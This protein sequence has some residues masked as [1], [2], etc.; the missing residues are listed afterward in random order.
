MSSERLISMFLPDGNLEGIRVIE[1][2]DSA[3][4]GF[5]VP[6]LKLNDT[7]DRPE[8]K[9]PALYLLINSGDNQIY[10]GESENFYSRVKTHDQAKDFWDIAVALVSN[11]NTLEK[12]DIKYLESLA[13]E[14]AKSTSASGILNKTVPTRNNVH[15]FKLHIL[16]K[17]IEDADLIMESLGYSVFATKREKEEIWYCKTKKTDA[18]AV[19]RGDQF[20]VLA[21][22]KIDANVSEGFKKSY[23]AAIELRI[24]IL[25]EQN[26]VCENDVYTLKEN[27]PFRSA[28][29]AGGF[30]AGRNIN[31]WTTWKNADGKTMD[32]VMRKGEK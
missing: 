1:L 2:S 23:P 29:T 4:K 32:E 8:L 25:T 18:K 14:R 20:V 21:G 30:V 31:A 24:K 17:F 19:F 13:V 11:T 12:G 7:K 15:E 22:S 27:V 26:I 10:I 5:V 6:R 3:V 28:N 16:E 9:Q